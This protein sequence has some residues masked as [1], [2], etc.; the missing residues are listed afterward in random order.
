MWSIS[1]PSTSTGVPC[2]PTTSSP[3]TAH[4]LEVPEAPDADALVPAPSAARRAGRAPR[5]R[6][7]AC[8]PRAATGRRARARRGTPRRAAAKR[9][10]SRGSRAS[11]SRCRGRAPCAPPVVPRRHLLEHARAPR[12]GLQAVGAR[13]SSRSRPARSRAATSARRLLDLDPCE[14]Q[15][16][17]RRLVHGLEQQL[18]AVHPFVRRLLQREQLVRAE[19]ALVVGPARRPGASGYRRSRSYRGSVPSKIFI[20]RSASATPPAAV[21]SHVSCM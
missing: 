17:L 21:T 1:R 3:M 20:G 12:D 16:Q 5:A 2:V 11:R 4:D 6:D 13:R 7:L 10:A 14:L 9:G 18:V 15:P 19:I 8:T